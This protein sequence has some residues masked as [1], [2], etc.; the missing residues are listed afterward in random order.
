MA[1]EP[2]FASDDIKRQLPQAGQLLAERK[3]QQ[4]QQP[5]VGK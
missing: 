5:W 4:Q 2:I 3:P 1:L